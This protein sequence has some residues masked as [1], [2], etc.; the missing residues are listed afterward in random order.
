VTLTI[1]TIFVITF[2]YTVADLIRRSQD[3]L[4]TRASRRRLH[5][6]PRG[7]FLR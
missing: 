3:W 7:R 1:A 4:D 2:T 6:H 5:A